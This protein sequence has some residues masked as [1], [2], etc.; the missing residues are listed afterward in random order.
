M[1]N[2]LTT[3]I[4]PIHN[5]SSYIESGLQAIAR[6]VYPT[7]CIEIL[8]ADGM[9]TDETRSLIHDFSVLHP[10]VKIRIMDNPGLVVP[11]GLNSAMR[12]AQGEF[13]IRVDG[14]TVIAPDYVRQCVAALQRTQA[15]NVGG[16]MNAIG[17]TPFG[18]AVAVATSTP[19]GI[20]GG[21]FHYSDREEWVDTVYMGAWPRRVFER[22]GLF[23]EE[24]VRDQDDEFNYRLRENGGKI[25]LS[26]AIKSEYTVRRTPTA[27]WKQYY[28]YGF[29]KVRVLQKHPHQMSLRQFVP[30]AF[31]LGL[32]ISVLFVFSPILRPLFPVIPLLYLVSN[33]FA[34]IYNA[35]KRGWEYLPL[36]PFVFAIL[37]VSYGTGFL[38]G[39]I[40]FTRRWGDR[41]GKVPSFHPGLD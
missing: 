7:D 2:P 10:Q 27:L 3:L 21:R 18:D 12:Q 17:V 4:L 22:I 9:S 30:P 6:Q 19:F 26:P 11:I 20:G 33:L 37:H 8:I 5:E 1:N 24:L 38:V 39:L 36:L 23:D 31:V 40:K 16:R 28:Q 41:A 14:H 13:I 29:W 15:D 32:L 34:S 35:F 25:L